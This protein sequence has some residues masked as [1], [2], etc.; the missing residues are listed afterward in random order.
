[1]SRLFGP[2]AEM[3]RVS[4]VRAKNFS[5]NRDL[6]QFADVT[7][8][9]V[10]TGIVFLRGK[11]FIPESDD[12]HGGISIANVWTV[13]KYVAICAFWFASSQMRRQTMRK[14]AIDCLIKDNIVFRHRQPIAVE[15]HQMLERANQAGRQ[16]RPLNIEVGT[17][18]FGSDALRE[19]RGAV[20][21]SDADKLIAAGALEIAPVPP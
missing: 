9:Q 4:T 8:K 18:E 16:V 6:R 13:V 19:P 3:D 15:Q 21:R 14:V 17:D 5:V 2:W 7:K 12:S 20:A 10:G 11:K 1:M